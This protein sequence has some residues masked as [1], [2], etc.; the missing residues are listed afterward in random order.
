MVFLCYKCFQTCCK[1]LILKP[2]IPQ[3]CPNYINQ[4]KEILNFSVSCR[5][6]WCNFFWLQLFT[7]WYH[8][9]WKEWE[10]L[11]LR[12]RGKRYLKI[13]CARVILLTPSLGFAMLFPGVFF[14]LGS[15]LLW[16]II[17][18]TPSS[19]LSGGPRVPFLSWDHTRP[20]QMATRQNDLHSP[21]QKGTKVLNMMGVWDRTAFKPKRSWYLYFRVFCLN[22]RIGNS[23]P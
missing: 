1:T 14:N 11:V 3:F 21:E 13:P 19:P 18:M 12:D 15:E 16:S 22:R 7:C 4:W 5:S 6:H 20:L 8:K 17:L 9:F 2:W 10:K 23:C